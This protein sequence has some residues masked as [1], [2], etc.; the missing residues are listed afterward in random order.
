[1]A[2]YGPRQEQL[3]TQFQTFRDLEIINLDLVVIRLQHSRTETWSSLII[4]SMS[5]F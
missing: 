2:F 3:F 1:M 5:N 4:F